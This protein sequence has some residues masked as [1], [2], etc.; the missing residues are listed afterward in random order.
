MN[1][2]GF[3]VDDNHF[4]LYTG[5]DDRGSFYI[6]QDLAQVGLFRF[7][8]PKGDSVDSCITIAKKLLAGDWFE[9][10]NNSELECSLNYSYDEK[11]KFFIVEDGGKCAHFRMFDP[12]LES[13]KEILKRK[14]GGA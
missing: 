5:R 4:L 8:A 1:V 3:W 10:E 9:I 6:L 14:K 11:G 12:A 7:Y 13:Y 2:N